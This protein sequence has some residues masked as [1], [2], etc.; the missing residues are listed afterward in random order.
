MVLEGSWSGYGVR[1]TMAHARAWT[2]LIET[3][4]RP[5][6]TLYLAYRVGKQY[7]ENR[8]TACGGVYEVYRL[9]D[10]RRRYSVRGRNKVTFCMIIA[11]EHHDST[12]KRP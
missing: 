3:T 1:T 7:T 6:T 4:N 8:T 12:G 2:S 11:S 5:A 10:S 9:V